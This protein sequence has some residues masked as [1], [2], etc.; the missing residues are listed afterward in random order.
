MGV[1]LGEVG[2]EGD[3]DGGGAETA[4]FWGRGVLAWAVWKVDLETWNGEVRMGR[5][6]TWGT[7]ERKW[8]SFVVHSE[9]LVVR[10]RA[11]QGYRGEWGCN[12]A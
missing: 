7:Y 3:E 10:R 4:V 1:L 6:G 11:A 5:G 9:M 8:L 2:Q 12:A